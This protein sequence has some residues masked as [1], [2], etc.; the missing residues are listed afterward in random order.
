M[1]SQHHKNRL[2]TLLT[3]EHTNTLN[4]D[5]GRSK[6]E[7]ER[8][9]STHFLLLVHIAPDQSITNNRYI[10]NSKNLIDSLHDYKLVVDPHSLQI[11]R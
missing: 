7:A 9:A 2:D 4:K 10:S 1:N 8:V 3:H 5:S 11:H 6:K